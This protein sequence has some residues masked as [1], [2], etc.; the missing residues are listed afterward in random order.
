MT[1]TVTLRKALLSSAMYLDPLNIYREYIQNAADAIDDALAQGLL[2]RGEVGRVEVYL[3]AD[4]QG[5]DAR[6]IRIRDNGTGVRSSEFTARLTALGGS[7]KRG[8]NSRG[9]R[10]VGRLAG[11]GYCQELIFRTKA[12]EDPHVSELRWNCRELKFLL[13]S[14]EHQDDL[15][16]VV[17]KSVSVRRVTDGKWPAHFFEVELRGV[18]RHK[19]DRLLNPATV[20]DYLAQVAPVPFSPDF[21]YGAEI[22]GKIRQYIPGQDIEVRINGAEP[23]YR[24]QRNQLPL[25]NG[26][27]DPFT[28]VVFVEIPSLD[29]DI[30]AFAWVLHHGYHGSIPAAALVKG[31]RFRCGNIQVGEDDILQDLFGEPRFNGWSVG[32]VHVIDKRVMPNGRRDHF[33]QGNHFNSLVG[34]LQPL[35]HDITR[36]CRTFSLKRRI[37]RDFENHAARI[38]ELLVAMRRSGLSAGSRQRLLKEAK[39]SL[40]A[41]EKLST[42]DQVLPA[43]KVQMESTLADLGARLKRRGINFSEESPLTKLPPAKRKLY[44]Q[45]FSL[46]FEHASNKT[47]ANA[48]IARIIERTL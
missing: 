20:A 9:F 17:R 36:K 41:M 22:A 30:G 16:D 47:V 23:I 26:K 32:E 5:R 12:A 46:I 21:K 7:K 11:L 10:G 40:T 38:N 15:S 4:A 33:E 25:S 44:E 35:T 19:D 29:G 45:M 18:V 31:F 8:T 37:L 2:P 43:V 24:P 28:D 6:S 3:S 48:L 13:R 14:A 39:A 1:G 42:K 34:H 27:S